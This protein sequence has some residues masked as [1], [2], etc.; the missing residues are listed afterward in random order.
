GAAALGDRSGVL[1]CDPSGAER[2]AAG[3]ATGR[4]RVVDGEALLLDRVGEVDGGADEV[5]G[6]HPVDDDRDACGVDVDVTVQ[7]PLVEEELVLQTRAPAR[8][9]RDAKAQI[10]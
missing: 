10:V 5:R 4:V 6:A 1:R 3:A 7:S 2:V 9:N 8:L